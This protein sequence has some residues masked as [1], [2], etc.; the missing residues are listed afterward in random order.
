[1]L[2]RFSNTMVLIIEPPG[3]ITWPCTGGGGGGCGG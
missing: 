2:A 1:V 3:P